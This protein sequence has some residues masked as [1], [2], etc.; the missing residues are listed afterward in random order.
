MMRS[1]LG[2]KASAAKGVARP[3]VAV[4][5][6]VEGVI[7]AS[8]S[9]ADAAP[10]VA[11]EPLPIGVLAP[12]I[13]SQNLLQPEAVAAAIRKALDQVDPRKRD[14]TLVVPNT[15]VRVFVLD[16]D[17]LPSKAAEVLSVLRFRL[18][19]MVPFDVEHAGL[20]FQILSS[21]P[22]ETRVLCAIL[23]ATVLAEYE[24]AIRAAGY[25]PGVVLPSSLAA[26]AALE[27]DEPLLAVFLQSGSMTSVIANGQDLLLYRTLE[28]PEDPQMKELEV[29]RDIAVAIAY[30]EDRLS[31]RPHRL[32]YAGP[33]TAQEFQHIVRESG[34]EVVELVK[35]L[36][37]R[38][39]AAAPCLAGVTGALAGVS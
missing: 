17:S 6:S 37:S 28:L 20:S 13:A 35:P 18:R 5:I 8:L 39:S 12:G 11:F 36:P 38:I 1:I 32:H 7:A 30:F 25:E 15:A 10:A 26:L 24:G 29:Q 27:S 34:C 33:S 3:P 19:K 21:S 14:V 16:F 31:V 22:Q 23:P 2:G 4:D 9:G